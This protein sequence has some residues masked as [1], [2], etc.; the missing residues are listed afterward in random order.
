MDINHSTGESVITSTKGY[1]WFLS[2]NIIFCA[3]LLLRGTHRSD[4][5]DL[6]LMLQILC[7]CII[8]LSLINLLITVK[9]KKNINDGFYHKLLPFVVLAFGLLWS[10]LFLNFTLYYQNPLITLMLT[11]SVLL[12]ATI[13]F[14][15]SGRLLLLF[16]APLVVCLLYVEFFLQDKFSVAQVVGAVIMLMVIYSAR[17]ILLEWYQRVQRSEYEKNILIKKLV[18]QAHYD[19]L[20][21][22]FNRLS[23]T[24]FFEECVSAL[25]G[26]KKKLFMIVMD[27][28][29]FKQYNDMYGHVAGD[30]CLIKVS[31]C[32]EKSL[33]K[34]SDSA[35]R[36]GGEEFV[37]LTVCDDIS[38]VK[39]I[40]HRIQHN[41]AHAH[42]AHKGSRISS[43]LTISQGIA[44]WQEG[45][46]LE[47]LV[48]KADQQLYKAK[49]QGRNRV[50]Y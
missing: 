21:G 44:Q 34:D 45:M 4:V 11:V 42:I 28:D 17:Y 5:E 49:E 12:P 25:A 30:K 6:P 1:M 2:L 46:T 26:N 35:F 3:W 39:A 36:F 33:R 43:V 41:I 19:A 20:T 7:G 9:I 31:Q 48:E 14:Y 27:I 13:T 8:A 22:L 18:Q 23:M 10:V 24:S 47:A 16:S 32:I 29:F 40:S 50:N 38:Q 37:V 15:I